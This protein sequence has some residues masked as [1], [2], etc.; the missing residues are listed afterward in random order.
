M[1][2]AGP[3]RNGALFI[4]I[5]ALLNIFA[6]VVGGFTSNALMLL[7]VG[8]F[9]TAIGYGLLRGWRWLAYVTF[10]LVMIGGIL[11]LAAI[12]SASTVPGWWYALIVGSDWL[13]AAALFPALWRAAPILSSK[14]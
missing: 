6:F 11:A 12:W 2:F 3:Y 10:F 14:S 1:N 4:L 13:S 8:F 7:P 5:S 9:Y